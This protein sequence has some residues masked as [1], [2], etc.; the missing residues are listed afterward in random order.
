MFSKC[1]IAN[2]VFSE[3]KLDNR[4]SKIL[5]FNDSCLGEDLFRAS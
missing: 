4:C 1:S 3:A 2:L 5:D